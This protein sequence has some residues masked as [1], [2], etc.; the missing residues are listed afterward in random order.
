MAENLD[1]LTEVFEIEV[2]YK[3]ENGV[4]H[5]EVE[6]RDMT[7]FDEELFAKAENRQNMGKFITT[8]LSTLVVRIGDLTP[9]EVGKTK[10]T[11]IFQSL[12]LGDRD[13]IMMEI[14][15]LAN[16]DEIELEVK[17][18]TCQSQLKHVVEMDVDIEH[19]PL[20]VDPSGFEFELPKGIKN[21]EGKLCKKGVIR[22]PDGQDQEVLANIAVKN[23]GMANTHLLQRTIVSLEGFEQKE[24]NLNLVRKMT[25]KD[26][27][28]LLELLAEN[29]FGPNLELEI[30][31]P[32]CGGD[33][34]RVGVHPVNF[35]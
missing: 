20:K 19:R 23:A 21:K 17:C 9:K 11:K 33:I 28:Y 26:R 35:L 18:P 16:G 25:S 14:R 15:K 1:M 29:S 3:D 7:G 2:G 5:K 27:T 13:K 34:E 30:T 22:L 31:C 4:V 8:V 6:I 10:W 24:I 12:Y 32:N